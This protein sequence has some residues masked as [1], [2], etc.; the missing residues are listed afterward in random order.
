MGSPFFEMGAHL[1]IFLTAL[2]YT[3]SLTGT[4][5]KHEILSQTMQWSRESY[6]SINCL[7]SAL[8]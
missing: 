8:T 4:I 2:I 3:K 7:D 6:E 5:T 1:Y